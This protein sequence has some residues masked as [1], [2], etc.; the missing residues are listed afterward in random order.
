[1]QKTLR[2]DWTVW[3]IEM[4]DYNQLDYAIILHSAHANSTEEAVPAA[5]G[6]RDDG[7]GTEFV[8][9]EDENSSG[10]VDKENISNES[11]E[12]IDQRKL[13][14]RIEPPKPKAALKTIFLDQLPKAEASKV[15]PTATASSSALPLT[16]HTQVD[17]ALRNLKKAIGLI[18]A[19]DAITTPPKN[20]RV[21]LYPHQAYGLEWLWWREGHFPGGGILGNCKL[22]W[23]WVLCSNCILFIFYFLHF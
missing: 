1:M 23:V 11:L 13:P 2:P 3:K 17:R 21:N 7:E 18:P 15:E 19:P 16:D 22:V 12:D 9:L 6:I 20:L 10:N 8:D 4:I 14:Q 5:T